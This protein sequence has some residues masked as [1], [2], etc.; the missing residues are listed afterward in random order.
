MAKEFIPR[1]FKY[2]NKELSDPNPQMSPDRVKSFFANEFPEL[3]TSNVSG[4]EYK[5]GKAYY[6]FSNSFKPKG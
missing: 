2:D 4:P 3:S 1:V 5:D 6:T